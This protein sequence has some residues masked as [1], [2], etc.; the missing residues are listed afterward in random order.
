[1]SEYNVDVKNV[2]AAK[3]AVAGAVFRAEAGTALPTDAKTALAEAFKSLGYISEDGYT[4][5][6]TASV[7]KIKAWGGAVVMTV[8]TEKP[9]TFKLKFIEGLRLEVLKAVYGGE[10]VTGT[11]AEGLTVKATAKEA[12]A[13]VWVIDEILNSCLHRCVIPSGKITTVSEITH[14]DN[15]PLGYEVEI[16]ALPDENG[17]TH[18]DYYSEG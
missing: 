11:I 6:N 5:S 2:T 17:V 12:E 7:D 15:E 18:F 3:P 10:N 1:M 16:E 14:K 4:N 9:D 13:C 8:Q